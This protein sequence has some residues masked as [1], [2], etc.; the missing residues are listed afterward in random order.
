MFISEKYSQTGNKISL[1]DS[2]LKN[3]GKQCATRGSTVIFSFLD[4]QL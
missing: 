4:K 3:V 1:C 2:P